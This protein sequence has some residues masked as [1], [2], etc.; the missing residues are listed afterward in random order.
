MKVAI[1]TAPR[2]CIRYIRKAVRAPICIS[3]L[4]TRP[5]PNQSTAT[6]EALSTS[7][8][9]GK[10]RTISRPA[11]RAVPVRAALASPKR[12]TSSSS[13]TNARTT[14]MPES[15]SRRTRLTV[16]MRACMARN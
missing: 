12:R 2:I 9:V 4:L 8:T 5:A 13:R 15:C 1:I 10:I 14:R 7:I 11:R 3:P 6:L 16:S